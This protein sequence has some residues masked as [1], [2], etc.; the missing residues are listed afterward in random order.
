MAP[1]GTSLGADPQQLQQRAQRP[2]GLAR[3]DQARPVRP[4]RLRQFVAL[5]RIAHDGI[6][7]D[8]RR[9]DGDAGSGRN[10]G[11]DSMV[12]AEVEEPARGDTGRGEPVDQQAP[13]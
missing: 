3:P 6:V 1:A 12:G 13:V 5:D 10:A 9:H 11:H 7:E 4:H 2:A 8:A